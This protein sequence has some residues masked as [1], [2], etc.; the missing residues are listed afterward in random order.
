MS[1]VLLEAMACGLPIVAT[2]VGGNGDLIS[3]RSNG[4]LVPPGDSHALSE[5]LIEILHNTALAQQLGDEAR[6]TVEEHYSLK[7]IT[8]SYMQLYNR[9]AS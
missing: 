5:A 3:D 6:R 7:C 2:A 9:L 8:D 1:N 4:I